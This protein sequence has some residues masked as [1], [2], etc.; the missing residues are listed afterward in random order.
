MAKKKAGSMK[1]SSPRSTG[2]TRIATKR[3]KSTGTRTSSTNSSNGPRLLSGGNP[4][5]A[6]GDGA[7]PV[8]A[9]IEAMPGWKRG[10]GRTLDALVVELVPGVKKAVRWNSPFY[11]VEQK[12]GTIGWFMSLHCI[13]RYVKVAFFDGTRL[14]PMPTEE[15]K[16]EGIRYCHIFEDVGLDE[17]QMRSWITQAARLPGMSWF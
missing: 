1:K 7:G 3:G 15:S 5:I 17:T 4:Q 11:G 12:D 10:V 13:T 14:K 6:K 2:S 9:Y 16:K 8:R